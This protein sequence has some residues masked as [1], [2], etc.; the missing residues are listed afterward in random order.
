[1]TDSTDATSSDASS[2]SAAVNSR[3]P[4][5][6]L[7]RLTGRPVVGGYSPIL[8]PLIRTLKVRHPKSDLDL[9]IRAFAVAEKYHEGQKRKSGDPYITHPVAVATILAELGLTGT[10]L[11][12]AL[13]HDTV[14]DTSYSLDQLSREFGEETALLVD[15]VTKLD[16]VKFG[17]AAQAETVR[18]M[19]LAM[20]KD[21]RVLLIKLADRL[22]NARTWRYVPPESSA[23][24]AKETLEIYA[25]LAHRLGMNTIKWELEDLSFA[26]LWPKVYSEIVRLVGERTPERQQNVAQLSEQIERELRDAKIRAT[27]SGR[28]KHYYSIYQKMIVRGKEFDEIYDLLGVRVLVDSVRDCYAALGVLHAKWSPIPG[29]FKDYIAMPKYNMYQSLHT[30]VVGSDGKRVEIQI[31]TH[32][33]HRRAEYGVAAHW[34]YKDAGAEENGD[35]TP[36]WLRAVLDWQKDAKDPNDF[37]DSLRTEIGAAEVYVFTP[38]GEIK[39]LPAGS[40]PVD[41]AYSVHTEVGDRTIGARV[42]GRLVPLNSPLNHGDSVEIFTSKSEDAGPSQ[43]WLGFVRSARARNKIR[44]WFSKERRDEV[45]EVGKDALTKYARKQSLP[46]SQVMSTD[47]LGTVA[48]ELGLADVSGLYAAIGENNVSAQNV[49][50][51]IQALLEPPEPPQEEYFDTGAMPQVSLPSR[52]SDSGVIIPGTGEVMAKLARCCSPV[53]PDDIVGFVTRGSGVSVHRTDCQNVENLK[54]EPERL[55]DVEWAPTQDSVF[56]VEIQVEALDR[57]SLLSDV[58]RILAEHHV[59]ILS[60]SVKTRRDRVAESQFVFEMGDPAYLQHVLNSIRRIDGVYDV[61]RTSDKG[62][63]KT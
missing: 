10:T 47:A 22:H 14:E 33:M 36:N 30:T 16:K 45:I 38:Q 41:F 57:K 13:L 40:T 23:R 51:H 11:A 25:P 32:E 28:P 17:A 12:A 18:K 7:A 27:L 62:Q 26:A 1:M 43:D 42:N 48:E 3:R 53:P 6:R 31:R 24:K 60:A 35:A 46:L 9:V 39:V 50:E 4:R 55:V 34:R 44:H 2:T 15:G 61:F 52:H 5:G 37:L 59:N 58:T 20:A 56:V 54:A 49:F 29:R 8:E 21:V 19:V 63:R